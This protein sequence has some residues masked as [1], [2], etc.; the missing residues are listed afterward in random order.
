MYLRR[1]GIV[2]PPEVPEDVCQSEECVKESERRDELMAFWTVYSHGTN[3]IPYIY[4]DLFFFF[5]PLAPLRK[6]TCFQNRSLIF[7][8]SIITDLR[9]QFGR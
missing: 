4:L 2:F 6:K 7:A 8:E 9:S 1:C 5:V 3:L